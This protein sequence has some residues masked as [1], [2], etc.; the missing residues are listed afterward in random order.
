M[1]KFIKSFFFLFLVTTLS[2]ASVFA[3]TSI[4]NFGSESLATA[5]PTVTSPVYY[6]QNCTKPLTA[7][8][9]VGGGT[10]NWYTVAV[11]GVGSLIAPTPITTT[12]GS[13]ITYYVSQINAGVESIRVPIVVNVV[14][15]NGAN[16]LLFRC[17]PSQIPKYSI[18]YS[19]PATINDAVLFDWSNN[20]LISNTYI[21]T[22]SIQGGPS[23]TEYNPN[24]E[25]HYIVPNLLPGQSVKLTLSSATHP[26]V[27]SQAITCSVPCGATT[28]TPTFALFGTSYCI[29]DIPP[30]LPSPT[31]TPAMTGLWNPSTINT[32]IT[33]TIIYT[34]IPDPILFPCAKSIPLSVT[35]K[36]IEPN[37][38][39]FSI[40]SGMPAPILNLVSPNGIRGTWNPLTIDNRNS[41][42][43][44]FTPN[45][46]QSCAPTVKTINVT[47]NPSNIIVSLNWTVTDA[48]IKNQIVTVIAPIGANYLYQLDFGIFQSSP[49]FEN[50][51]FGMHSITVKDVNGCSELTNN[52]ILVIGYPKFFTPN[53]DTYNDIWNIF[54]LQDQLNSR[55]YIFDRYGKLLKDISPKDIGWD[56]N[57]I[58][59]PMPATDYW[60]T[61]E[62]VEQGV[63]KKYKSHF[64]LKR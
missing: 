23:F 53:G 30:P 55:I 57:Y 28:I 60:F 48:F 24:N 20:P 31:N 14:A 25:S 39:D 52:N 43:Y 27:P 21:C 44:V 64:S 16:I 19:P 18:D 17:D 1:R 8:L 15:D 38:T 62:Y 54:G 32:T 29:N 33:G 49:I 6:W 22:Y 61:V 13:T 5:P 11:G 42:S 47:V 12:I 35:V 40:C 2:N 26:C 46:G 10:L 34:F 51:S 37:F 45:S 63:I 50:V 56:G 58:G 4:S 9:S 7:I 3:R 36:P 59:Q 41:S